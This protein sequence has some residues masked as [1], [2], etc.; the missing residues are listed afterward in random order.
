VDP[1]EKVQRALCEQ[2]RSAWVPT[3]EDSILGFAQATK[4]RT[5]LNGLRH[6]PAHGSSGWYIWCGE[7]WSDS[8]EFFSPLHASHV[9]AAYPDLIRLL[10]LAPGYRFLMTGS[11]LDVWYDSHLLNV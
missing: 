10:G 6:P 5:P 4:G 9:Y 8:P 7:E 11:Y 1:F 2:Y 3:A